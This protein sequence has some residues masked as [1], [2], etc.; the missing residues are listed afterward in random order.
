MARPKRIE[1]EP[2][3]RQ[4]ME[5]AFWKTLADM[6]Y[7]KMTSREVCKR[8]GVSHNTFY[9]HFENLDDMAR[10]MLDGLFTPELPLALLSMV[11]G[12]R[13]ASIGIEGVPELQQRL[14]KMRLLVSSGSTELVVLVQSNVL[15]AWFKTL[16]VK[17]SELSQEDLIDLTFVVGGITALLGSGIVPSDPSDIASF[18]EREVGRGVIRK[19]DAI[20]RRKQCRAQNI[21][22]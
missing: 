21:E 6:P 20:A 22:S 8:S 19:M 18:A 17:K 4:R 11:D 3:A 10:R 15:K 14:S 2:T 7:H 9:Y 16:G 12:D 1:G 13:K 5:E